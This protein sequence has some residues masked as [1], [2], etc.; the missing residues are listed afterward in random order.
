MTTPL[1]IAAPAPTPA[2]ASPAATDA[3]GGGGRLA[4]ALGGALAASGAVLPA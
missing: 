2:S 4:P 1:V 3:P